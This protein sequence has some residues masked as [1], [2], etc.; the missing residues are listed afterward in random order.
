MRRCFFTPNI[1]FNG[2]IKIE[3]STFPIE[4][5]SKITCYN[6]NHSF[7]HLFDEKY[8]RAFV[9]CFVRDEI[10]RFTQRDSHFRR[11]N[12]LESTI[13]VYCSRYWNSGM[14]PEKVR[15]ES[16]LEG[17]GKTHLVSTEH[18]KCSSPSYSPL[19]D[20][21]LRFHQTPD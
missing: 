17:P 19:F 18:L 10:L 6:F 21:F 9:G 7:L 3:A 12:F 4:S 16:K 5:Q 13:F 15:S 2:T 11:A 8:R 20:S 14:S 1:T